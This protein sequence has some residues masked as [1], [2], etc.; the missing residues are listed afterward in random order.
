[1]VGEKSLWP[2][3]RV[4]WAEERP[5]GRRKESLGRGKGHLGAEKVFWIEERPFVRTHW[6][7]LR[8]NDFKPLRI[9]L[10]RWLDRIGGS[11]AV[12]C[13]LPPLLEDGPSAGR[14]ENALDAGT[15]RYHRPHTAQGGPR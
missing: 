7:F 1:L 8:R 14:R 10:F 15:R 13:R 9:E 3:E 2:E 5:F 6:S 12:F 4:F 11:R